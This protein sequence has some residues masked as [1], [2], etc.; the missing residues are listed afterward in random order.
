MERFINKHQAVILLL[1]GIIATAVSIT[2]F[3]YTNFSTKAEV[4]E[5]KTD[6]KDD[7][8]EIKNDIKL[9]LQRE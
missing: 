4:V 6:I 2:V 7:I 8:K 3:A 9:L 1:G 5:L